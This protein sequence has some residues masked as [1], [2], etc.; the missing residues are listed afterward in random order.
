MAWIYLV[1]AGLLEVIWAYTMK[2]SDGFTR[3][4]YSFITLVAMI[5]SFG[6]LAVAMKSL[7]L[8]TAYTIWTG[9]GAVGAFV[10]GILM[11][12]EVASP[13]RILAAGLIVG[14]LV[15]MKLSS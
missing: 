6:L 9:I 1:V 13:M 14:G 12:G 8:G 10:V 3:L 7:P 11:L 4:N 2:L 15:L 5:A